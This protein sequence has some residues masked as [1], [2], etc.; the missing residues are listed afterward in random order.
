MNPRSGL[1]AALSGKCP[2]CRQ[3]DMFQYPL[4]QFHKF[5]KMNDSCSE[6]G[7]R[8]EI[9]PGF[10]IGAMYFSYAVT[11]GL[12]IV[13]GLVLYW[14]DMYEL[15]IYMTSVV[16]INIALTPFIFRYSRISFLYLFG[17]VTYRSR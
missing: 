8:Y 1:G 4:I 7:L 3:G 10:F 16:L 14:L 9:E 5:L 13:V 6:C 11:V 2:R 17:G 12:L 15:F